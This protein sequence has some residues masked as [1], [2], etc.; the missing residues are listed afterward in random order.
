M[1]SCSALGHLGA[2]VR[3]KL[4]VVPVTAAV[5]LERLGESQDCGEVAAKSTCRSGLVMRPTI[6]AVE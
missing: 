2:V 1:N 3:I 5:Y 6:S 4:R